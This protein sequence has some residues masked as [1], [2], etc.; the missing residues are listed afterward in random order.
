M[1]L[2]KKT[3]EFQNHHIDSTIWNDLAIRDDDV[4]VATYAKSGT[5]WTQQIVSQL[6]AHGDESV[7]IA[8]K[9]PWVDLRVPPKEV[10][11][12]LLSHY[13]VLYL[14]H[15]MCTIPTCTILTIHIHTHKHTHTYTYCH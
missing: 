11:L 13:T 5:T 1:E 9:S 3:Q 10:K 15:Y 6:L 14:P 7:E 12:H 2:P 4:I 8:S